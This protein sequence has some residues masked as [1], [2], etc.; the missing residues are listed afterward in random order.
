[1]LKALLLTNRPDT[2]F[3]KSINNYKLLK[4]IIT[5]LSEVLEKVLDSIVNFKVYKVLK[6]SFVI[7]VLI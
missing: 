5:Y 4:R 1:M 6:N 7:L 2:S 3:L